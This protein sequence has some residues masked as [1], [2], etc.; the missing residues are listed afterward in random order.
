MLLGLNTQHFQLQLVWACYNT[1]REIY[2]P[3]LSFL[4]AVDGRPLEESRKSSQQT[5]NNKLILY[6]W[7]L[8]YFSGKIRAFLRFQRNASSCFEFE[9]VV[10]TPQ[11]MRQVLLNATRTHTVPQVRMGNGT[12]VHDSTCIMDEVVKSVPSCAI[13]EPD[14]VRQRIAC[15]IL[16]LIGDE[17]LLVP[18]YHWRWAYSGNGTS[19]QQMPMV[20]PDTSRYKDLLREHRKYNCLQ[21]G[22]FLSPQKSTKEQEQIGTFLIDNL[23]LNGNI[24]IK[25]CMRDLGVTDVSVSAWES[26]CRRFLSKFDEHL[27][28]IP[29]ILGSKPSTADFALLGP[30]YAHLSCDP[31]PSKYMMKE[32]YPN[33]FNWAQRLHDKGGGRPA[34]R[35]R[36]MRN[37][38]VPS[39][40]LPLLRIFFEEM[41]PVLRSTCKVLTRYIQEEMPNKLPGGSFSSGCMDQEPGGPLTHTFTLPFDREGRY[42]G[43]TA[44]SIKETRMVLPY[45][46]WLLQRLEKTIR[47]SEK[48]A[49]RGFLSSIDGLELLDLTSILRKCRVKKINGEIFVDYES[50]KRKAVSFTA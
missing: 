26:S 41:W 4:Q 42:V 24:A 20:K 35:G 7:P 38:S 48:H 3:T 21:W 45:Q 8:S 37:D 13:V 18:A 6:Q 39:T 25:Q 16:E 49:I 9:E 14:T 44:R 29:Y 50:M 12:I 22:Y 40:V 19:T 36:W 33:V 47:Q 43:D 11:I 1:N 31:Y 46:I 23:M 34:V 27:E 32:D 15:Q 17:W 10:A 5:N 30:I 2:I 28:L